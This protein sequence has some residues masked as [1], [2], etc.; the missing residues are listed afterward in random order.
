MCVRDSASDEKLGYLV[1][2]AGYEFAVGP[3]AAFV[4]GE[5]SGLHED[6]EVVGDCGL[7]ETQRLGEVA[8]AR[9]RA[10]V[11]CDQR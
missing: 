7:T 6:L 8:D 9:L 1:E 4:A 2:G 11:G 10:L 3:G 5:N